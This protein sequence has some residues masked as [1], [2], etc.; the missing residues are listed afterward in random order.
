VIDYYVAVDEEIGAIARD[1]VVRM[2]G[3]L[4][5]VV[6]DSTIL[7]GDIPF[8]GLRPSAGERRREYVGDRIVIDFA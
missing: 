4:S 6:P 5:L 8:F 3:D 2:D 1:S 7:F